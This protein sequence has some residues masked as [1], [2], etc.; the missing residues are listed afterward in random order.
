[1]N[2][3]TQVEAAVWTLRRLDTE[4]EMGWPGGYDAERV[5]LEA[6]EAVGVLA[7]SVDAA[8]LA[9]REMLARNYVRALAER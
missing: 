3:D 5:R 1:M 6:L 7:R 2:E 8:G 9:Y 4:A